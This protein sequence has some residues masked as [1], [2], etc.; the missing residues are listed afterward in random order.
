MFPICNILLEP[1]TACSMVHYKTTR[2]VT[3]SFFTIHTPYKR[4]LYLYRIITT[5]HLDDNHQ[6]N[7]CFRNKSVSRRRREDV[8]NAIELL[9]KLRKVSHISIHLVSRYKLLVCISLL[10][11]VFS[12]SDTSLG[13]GSL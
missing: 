9:L 12:V 2:K 5:A 8:S 13:T 3:A 10:E 6:R 11:D 7:L 4:T 1:M